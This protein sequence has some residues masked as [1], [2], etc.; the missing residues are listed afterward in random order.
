MKIKNIELLSTND[1]GSYV[2]PNMYLYYAEAAAICFEENHYR[3]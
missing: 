3:I 1:Y 2:L